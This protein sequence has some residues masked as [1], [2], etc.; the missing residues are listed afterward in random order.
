[1]Y[2]EYYIARVDIFPIFDLNIRSNI[3][4]DNLSRLF[5]FKFNL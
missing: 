2:S 4:F 3:Y 1:M 5:Y